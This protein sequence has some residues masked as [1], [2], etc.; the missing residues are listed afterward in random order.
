MSLS[1]HPP[2]SLAR[3]SPTP[4]RDFGAASLLTLRVTHRDPSRRG[5]AGESTPH[6][7]LV[8]QL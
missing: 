3:A 8:P 2:P 1:M 7:K 6:L 4:T 5:P